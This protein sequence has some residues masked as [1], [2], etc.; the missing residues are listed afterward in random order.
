MNI[1]A[2]L[3]IR[4]IS[5]GQTTLEKLCGILDLP[6][7]RHATTVRNIQKN[8]VN[9]YNNVASQYMVSTANEVEGVRDENGI[10]DIT[11]SYNG[12]RQK[13]GYNSLNRIATVISVDRGKSNEY[14]IRTKNCKTCQSW[15]GREDSD[16][17]E[18]FISTHELNCYINNHGSAGG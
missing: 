7:P 4:K 14:R 16:E 13:R 2:V 6:E 15:E 8:I 1:R 5:R 18:E 12:P 17:Y 3:A 11:V 9:A 10:C